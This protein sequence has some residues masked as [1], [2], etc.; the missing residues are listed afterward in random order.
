MG[1]SPTYSLWAV[2]IGLVI[3][4][5]WFGIDKFIHPNYWIQ[6]W[7]PQWAVDLV[8]SF[9]LGATQL[10]YVLGVVEILIAVSIATGV[11]IKIAS[12]L[13]LALIV[14][15]V[16]LHGFG[17]IAVRDIGLMGGLLAII[18][19]PDRELGVT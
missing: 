16:I 2:R 17:E 7:V 8:G 11:F 9:G 14:G 19:W 3:V 4:F 13:A 15:I 1:N 6:A 5:G 10:I 12:L 18:L